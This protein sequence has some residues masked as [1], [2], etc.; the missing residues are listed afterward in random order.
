MPTPSASAAP[1]FFPSRL[2]QAVLLACLSL[3]LGATATVAQAQASAQ[4]PVRHEIPA[5][6]LD[7]VLTRFAAT[8][9]VPL[10]IDGQLTAGKRSAGLSGSYGVR[11]GL[12][13]ILAGSGLSVAEQP[14]GGYALVKAP[15]AA[16]AV[17]PAALGASG[18]AAL[19][20]VKIR[21]ATTL[22]ATTEGTGSY[23][24]GQTSASTGLNLTLRETPQSVSVVTR[25]RLDDQ[26]ITQLTDVAAQVTGLTMTQSGNAGSDT[27]T[28]YSRGF[29]VENYLID[30]VGQN[31]SNYGSIFQTNDL[32]IF[33][34]VEVVRGASGLMNGV[35]SPGATLNLVRKK[36]TSP[37]QASGRIEGGS[38]NYYRAEVDVSGALNAAGTLRGR[39]VGA[40]QDNDSYIDRLHE[41]KK[42]L[43]GVLEAD[44]TENTL[45]TA[46]FSL[47]HHDATAHARG[48]LPT[49]DING[50]RVAWSRSASA[51]A[52]WAYSERH[53]QSLFASVEHR[54][55]AGWSVK[56]T[57]SRNE[58]DYDER[59]GYAQGGKLVPGTGTG[60]SVW[61]SGWDGQ[62]VQ[63]NFDVRASGPF[64]AF[65][66]KHD[67]M[68]GASTSRTEDHTTDFPG[69]SVAAVPDIFNWDGNT[70]SAPVW[71]PRGS[72]GY[73]ERLTSAFAATRLKPTDPLS[74]I[75]GARVTDWRTTTAY[76][77]AAGVPYSDSLREENGQVTP[78]VGV[79]YDIDKN[80]SA[81]ASYTSIFK[82]QSLRTEAGD[83][84]Q[85]LVGNTFEVGTK[86]AFFD[87][88]LNLSGAIYRIEQDNFGVADESKTVIGSTEQAY[89]S[90]SGTLTRGFEI[91]ASG[92]LARNWQLTAGFSRN[93]SQKNDGSLL[94]PT[95]PANTFKLFTTYRIDSIGNG[96]TIGG[97]VRWQ[98]D[99]YKDVNGFVLPDG[100]TVDLRA[101]QEAYAVADV[102][103]RYQ[104]NRNVAVSLNVNNLFDKSYFTQPLNSYYGA[105]RNVRVGLE[106]K[107]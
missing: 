47:Q 16:A 62:P 30:G 72:F 82:P 12:G 96:L 84:L 45:V 54:F 22:D 24:T 3:G 80:W 13:A 83:Y 78:F 33:D 38:W 9:G 81:Y 97:G 98:S 41:E 99:T 92:A 71:G 25:Q 70:P 74:V 32:V 101:E 2:S 37:F 56:G 40:L 106:A 86:A 53:N 88:Q 58:S 44:I 57:F 31:Y 103:A 79:V 93:L 68:V 35:G 34:R 69:W 42:V 11:D 95:I 75:L 36:P 23:T 27:T 48:G 89:L 49:F 39:A 21:S 105:P 20:A 61:G 4:A 63:E 17:A 67:L 73:T 102:M 90:E 14:G 10:T 66:R 77:D 7:D 1:T 5:G 29:A 15:V 64:E 94:D 59:L 85:P 65:G 18:E 46:G 6:P 55:D 19:P 50:S 104:V 26:G 107:F 51:A 91:E 52:N 87:N 28:I 76:A 8:A 43:Y 100:S 60:I